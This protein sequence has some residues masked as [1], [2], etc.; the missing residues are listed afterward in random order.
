MLD[1]AEVKIMERLEGTLSEAI[2][3]GGKAGILNVSQF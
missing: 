3:T 1:N 2:V